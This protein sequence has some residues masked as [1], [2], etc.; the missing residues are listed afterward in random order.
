MP[1]RTD[2]RER[3]EP[4]AAARSG[5]LAVLLFFAAWILWVVFAG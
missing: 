2:R 3:G 5:R 1:G 4:G